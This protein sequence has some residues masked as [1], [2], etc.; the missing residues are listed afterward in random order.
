MAEI[1]FI[2]PDFVNTPEKIT[3]FFI[4][5]LRK[6][7][8]SNAMARELAEMLDPN[9]RS[10]FRLRVEQRKA[11]NKGQFNDE[12]YR[13]IEEILDKSPDEKTAVERASDELGISEIT[14][15][16]YLKLI[17]KYRSECE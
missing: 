15:R 3:A 1:Y 10:R 12:R 16:K 11:G 13:K 6:G 5:R 17:N 4:D 7:N 8:I 2:D 14:A 9:G